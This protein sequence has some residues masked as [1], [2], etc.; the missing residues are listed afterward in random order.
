M[1]K[2]FEFAHFFLLNFILL[3]RKYQDAQDKMQFWAKRLHVGI[4]VFGFLDPGVNI[5]YYI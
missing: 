2:C 3:T 5:M 1:N 4:V